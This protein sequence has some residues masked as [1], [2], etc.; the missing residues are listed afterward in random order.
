MPSSMN[1]DF[2]FI[3][4]LLDGMPAPPATQPPPVPQ[5]S[6][7]AEE[8]INYRW[9]SSVTSSPFY[10]G[11]A[12]ETV[13]QEPSPQWPIGT[14][15]RLR[16]NFSNF[17]II[18]HQR[19]VRQ[20]YPL[21][22][23]MKYRLDGRICELIW[24]GYVEESQENWELNK[25]QEA[26]PFEIAHYQEALSI[27]NP[28]VTVPNIGVVVEYI[29]NIKE[30]RNKRMVVIGGYGHNQIEGQW[31]RGSG[32]ASDKI[33][34]LWSKVR[35][36]SNQKESFVPD[37]ANYCKCDSCS[38]I[39][40]KIS[41]IRIEDKYFCDNTC[42]QHACYFICYCNAWNHLTTGHE[43]VDGIVCNHCYS[44]NYA[45]C[46][47]CNRL[48]QRMNMLT[49]EPNPS[50]LQLDMW[51]RHCLDNRGRI[52]HDYS[53]KPNPRFNKMA[54]ENTRYLGIELE[55][56]HKSTAR[57]IFAERVKKW[58]E[59]HKL[60][61]LVYFKNDGSLSNG[62]EIVFHPFT[63]KSFHKNFPGKDFLEHLKTQ[64]GDVSSGKCGMHVHVSKEKLSTEQL[65]K[66]KWFFYKCSDFLKIFSGRN[67]FDYCHFEKEP[68]ND[69]YDQDF[70][71]HS[72]FNVAG[73]TKTLEI[74][75]FNATLEYRKFLA[76]LQFADVFVDYI[77]NG[78]GGAFL[79]T[80][81]QHII[82]QNFI[83]YMKKDGK[84]QVL[85]NYILQNAIV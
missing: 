4:E 1:D 51:C 74:R 20:D 38:S 7:L 33:R 72:A 75:I 34:I 5:P 44:N 46:V 79:K 21:A 40:E 35:I 57:E 71:R 66:G 69:P 68:G 61:K 82:W 12:G 80:Q 43:T 23:V 39:R 25:W 42:A 53:Y 76:N 60:N 41:T 2:I 11:N 55:V 3:H 54:W 48:H 84:Y 18:C 37:M 31:L 45:S 47:E 70:G 15:L 22:K 26:N 77:Q 81:N 8:L 14:I 49:G 9:R 62:I 58:L 36:S 78:A 19:E 27:L 65:I 73:S 16:N 32:M 30:L 83:D 6:S 29:G 10:F 59:A 52:I 13:Y 63:L 56:E 24:I 28:C 85:S 17:S 50:T 64:G 67:R